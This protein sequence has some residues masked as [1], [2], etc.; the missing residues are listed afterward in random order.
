M[1][2]SLGSEVAECQSLQ[3]EEQESQ[4]FLIFLKLNRC[5]AETLQ[6][7]WDMISK[8]YENAILNYLS[9][10]LPTFISEVVEFYQ[11]FRRADE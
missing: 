8:L 11:Q 5:K 4:L 7:I 3:H 6:W 2:S 1:D 9:S 10:V